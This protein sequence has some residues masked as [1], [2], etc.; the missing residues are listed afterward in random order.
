MLAALYYDDVNALSSEKGMVPNDSVSRI[1]DQ[2]FQIASNDKEHQ[3]SMSKRK[4]FREQDEL[5]EQEILAEQD[6]VQV[7]LDSFFTEGLISEILYTVKSG[8]EA[9]VYCCKA[10]PKTG[11]KL[12]AAKIYRSRNNRGFKND[13]VYQEGRVI[14]DR[15]VRRAVQNKSS[16]G[17]EAQFAMWVNYEFETLKALYKAGA[18]IP[19]PLA[20]TKSAI[21]MEYFGDERQAAP[22]LQSVE[23][24]RDEVLPVFERLMGNIELWLAHNYVHADLSAYNVL[25][26]QGQVHIIDFPQAVDPRFNP[27]AFTLLTRDIEN[28]CSYAARYG[29]ERNGLRI[30]E[31][32]WRRFK[33]AEL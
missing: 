24:S 7:A 10:N 4:L 25:Y 6:P 20:R 3:D 16:F 33:N 22:S 26:W 17:R 13:A 28:I 11:A 2:K 29:L 9:T 23:L 19:R 14:L 8:K 18:D 1:P 30:A 15:H 5:E 12:L 32:L 21:L 31:Q 27:N